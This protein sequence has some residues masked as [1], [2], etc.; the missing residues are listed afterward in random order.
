[1]SSA[2]T[3][4]APASGVAGSEGSPALIDVV[5]VPQRILDEL[6]TDFS[7]PAEPTEPATPGPGAEPVSA[8]DTGPLRERLT[9]VI[10]G[11][12]A[13]LVL[14]VSLLV[15]RARRSRND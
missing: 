2:D 1:V 6:S 10:G 11:G 3:G 15:A 9:W 7:G 14:A 4:S 8:D 12:G 13:L 5:P